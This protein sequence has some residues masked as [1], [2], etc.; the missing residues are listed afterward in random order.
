MLNRKLNVALPL[1][2]CPEPSDSIQIVGDGEVDREEEKE[3]CE[4]EPDAEPEDEGGWKEQD[5]KRW[6]SNNK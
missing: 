2:L 4:I 6:E 1:N 5:A 3:E